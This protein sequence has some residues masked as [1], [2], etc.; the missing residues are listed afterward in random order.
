MFGERYA[1]LLE[2]EVFVCKISGNELV[3]KIIFSKEDKAQIVHNIYDRNNPDCVFLYFDKYRYDR[4]YFCSDTVLYVIDIEKDCVVQRIHHSL[5]ET[6]TSGSYFKFHPVDKDYFILEVGEHQGAISHEIYTYMDENKIQIHNY[7]ECY[8]GCYEAKF[9][10][11]GEMIAYQSLN[12]EIVVLEFPSFDSVLTI[13]ML[14]FYSLIYGEEVESD[15]VQAQTTME[16][17][18]YDG[19]ILYFDNEEFRYSGENGIYMVDIVKL[20]YC[21]IKKEYPEYDKGNGKL[22]KK[23]LFC[24][25]LAGDCLYEIFSFLGIEHLLSK[26]ELLGKAFHNN[27]LIWKVVSDSYFKNIR[28]DISS[29]Y[30]FIDKY[31][32]NNKYRYVKKKWMDLN[33]D[34]DSSIEE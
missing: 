10:P 23:E 3:R 28:L 33:Q 13:N 18:N 4:M 9:S 27:F 5:H 25:K 2:G 22:E 1:Y 30:D 8:G 21:V 29:K 20:K 16:F 34:I 6:Y 31:L 17:T 12:V 26:V 15:F 11:R 32:V 24:S 19:N 7:L 14:K